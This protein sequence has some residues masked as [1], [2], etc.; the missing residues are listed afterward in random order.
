MYG[1]VRRR[2]DGCGLGRVMLDR[3]ADLTAAR[4]RSES[5]LRYSEV[6]TRMQMNPPLEPNRAR[7]VW[8]N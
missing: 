3:A 8:W 1:S 5:L 4:E 7:I 6:I 2:P